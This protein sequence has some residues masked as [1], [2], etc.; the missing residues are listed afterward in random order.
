MTQVPQL[1]A[2]LALFPLSVATRR[3]PGWGWGGGLP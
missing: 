3:L 2:P 1:I